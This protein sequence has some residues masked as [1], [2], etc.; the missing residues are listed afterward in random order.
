[1]SIHTFPSYITREDG[2]VQ[3]VTVSV[4]TY[5]LGTPDTIHGPGDDPEIDW[6]LLDEH[7][8]PSAIN[9]LV[10]Q[11]DVNRIASEIDREMQHMAR[12]SRAEAR[13]DRWLDT[14]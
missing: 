2:D 6:G 5:H 3:E 12:E 4:T 10:S 1:M 9:G 13:F 11:E 8:K 14:I 7:G